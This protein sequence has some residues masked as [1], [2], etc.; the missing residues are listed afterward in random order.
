MTQA[1]TALFQSVKG[2]FGGQREQRKRLSAR[3]EASF[4]RHLSLMLNNGIPITEALEILPANTADASSQVAAEISGFIHQGHSLTRAF[5]RIADKI[6]PI[7]PAM[8][9]AGER[10][11]SLVRTLAISADWAELAADVRARTLSVLY[12]PAFVLGVNL[13]LTILMLSYVFPVFMP[14]FSG[15]E[16]PFLTQFFIVLSKLAGSKL[17][18]L[19][20]FI[21]GVEAVWYLSQAEQRVRVYRVGLFIPV[22]GPLLRNAARTRFCSVLSI[23][24][25]AGLPLMEALRLA[26]HASGDPDMVRLDASLQAD[27][28]AGAS[29]EDHFLTYSEVY[30]L[31]LSH[32][33]ALSQATGKTD[34]VFEHMTR[35]FHTETE[36]QAQIFQSLIEPL[37]IGMVS[38]TTGLLL[39][40]IYLPLGKFLQG[41]VS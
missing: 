18:W 23:T 34:S 7:C 15:E 1:W 16:L 39:L 20:T 40:A 24:A 10:S 6:S 12:Y 31:P 11:G 29:P 19:I 30:G 36:T 3:E 14:L 28:R 9:E 38:F 37:L 26:A 25:K 4:L 27:V 41:L 13:V 5:R 21:A 32:G 2:A 22:L 17:V 33:M 8:V 35:L